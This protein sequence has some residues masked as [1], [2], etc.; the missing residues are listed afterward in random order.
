MRFLIHKHNENEIARPRIL[1]V[2]NPLECCFQ[3]TAN[4]SGAKAAG[5]D[6]SI[7]FQ[8]RKRK[9]GGCWEG[10][11]FVGGKGILTWQSMNAAAPIVITGWLVIDHSSSFIEFSGKSI[12]L[13]QFMWNCCVGLYLHQ[14]WAPLG[15]IVFLFVHDN[16]ER[17]TLLMTFDYSPDFGS[18]IPWNHCE[19]FRRYLLL[20][21]ILVFYFGNSG[22]MC[23]LC[24][25]YKEHHPQFASRCFRSFELDKQQKPSC[26]DWIN[27][28]KWPVLLSS[29]RTSSSWMTIWERNLF[30]LQKCTFY[31]FCKN[32]KV[33]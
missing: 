2:T 18:G 14:W 17:L 26:H 3:Q 23:A 16:K 22:R 27:S 28:M 32:F 11:K 31:L 29:G 9:S 30:F 5:R 15:I 24:C 4:N 21:P 13:I 12:I 19:K 20:Q 10:V 1:W 25:W 8:M 6:Q 33:Y 7:V